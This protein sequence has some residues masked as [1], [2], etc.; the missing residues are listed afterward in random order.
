MTLVLITT[1]NVKVKAK[2]AVIRMR[3]VVPGFVTH[4]YLAYIKPWV[5]YS[6]PLKN[7]NTGVEEMA[8][9]AKCMLFEP[10]DPQKPSKMS[11]M[12]RHTC[13][14]SSGKT[15][16]ELWSWL[17]SRAELVSSGFRQRPCFREYG[18]Q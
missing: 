7:T 9:W 13:N 6:V 8:Q 17:A 10:E 14:P 2:E 12:V 11:S 16:R 1:E 4:A 15:D 18:G 5:Q 3:N